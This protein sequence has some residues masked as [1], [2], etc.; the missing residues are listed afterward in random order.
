MDRP[1]RRPAPAPMGD[2]RDA[3]EASEEEVAAGAASERRVPWTP[4]W[5]RRGGT[6]YGGIL[7]AWR[8][9]SGD[10]WLAH[11]RWGPAPQDV[12]WL[13]YKGAGLKAAPHPDAD[14]AR[15]VAGTARPGAR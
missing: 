13:V 15:P 12:A 8:L 14:D 9:A 4:V 7:D 10:R 11:V 5:V 6:W 3:A 1:A 2:W